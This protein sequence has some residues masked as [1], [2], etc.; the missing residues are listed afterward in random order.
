MEEKSLMTLSSYR[1]SVLLD[2][3]LGQ[4]QLKN[5]AALARLLVVNPG[6]VSRVRHRKMPI[7]ANLLLNMHELT[8][9][10]IPTLR[11]LMGDS[12]RLFS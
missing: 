8:A 5:D 11:Y 7:S 12:R 6:V 2:H 9:I 1:P 4:L 3:L 10:A